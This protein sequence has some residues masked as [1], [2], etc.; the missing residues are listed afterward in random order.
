MTIKHNHSELIVRKAAQ[1]D[2]AGYWE[3]TFGGKT[4]HFPAMSRVLWRALWGH[5]RRNHL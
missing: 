2:W 4:Q 1:G 3:V 5:F